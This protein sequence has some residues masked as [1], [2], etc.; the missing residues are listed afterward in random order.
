MTNINKSRKFNFPQWSRKNCGLRCFLVHCW[1]RTYQKAIKYRCQANIKKCRCRAL[2]IWVQESKCGT[3]GR[4][5]K[6]EAQESQ[7]NWIKRKSTSQVKNALKITQKK[8][9]CMDSYCAFLDWS[10]YFLSFFLLD[11][12]LQLCVY[13]FWHGN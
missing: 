7:Y 2:P 8:M 5:E 9:T 13:P 4:G 1:P 12:F 6:K 3:E 11:D 10:F